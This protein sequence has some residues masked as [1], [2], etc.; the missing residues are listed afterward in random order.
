VRAKLN[1][2]LAELKV[3]VDQDRLEQELAL[4]VQRLDVDEELDRLAGHIVEIRRVIGGNEPR[5]AASTSSCRSSTAKPT[6]CHRSHRIS[7]RHA[8]RWI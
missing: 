6:R 2:R 5:D 7:R 1:E 4:L 8:A 3:N